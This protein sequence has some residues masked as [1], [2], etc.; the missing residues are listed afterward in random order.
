MWAG[1][2]PPVDPGGVGVCGRLIVQIRGLFMTSLLFG[3]V[4]SCP[5]SRSVVVL[6][7]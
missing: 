6:V 5:V 3:G 1:N 2:P 4:V 7:L